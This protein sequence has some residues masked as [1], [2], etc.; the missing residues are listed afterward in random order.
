[1]AANL[2]PTLHKSPTRIEGLDQI[3]QGGLPTGRTT[4][5]I[6]GPG[7]GKSLFGLEFLYRGALSG[8]P[9]IFITFEER[10]SALRE[11]AGTLGWQLLPL[12]EKGLFFLFEARIDP[13]AVIAGE[14]GIQSFFAILDH[15]LKAMGARRVVIDALDVLMRL[16]NDEHREQNELVA[17]HR[18][19]EE[20]DI[21]ALVSVKAPR[22]GDHQRNYEFLDYLADC[23]I[24]LDNRMLGQLST[25]R[26]RV[27][28]YRGSGF[29]SNEY[30]FVIGPPGIMLLPISEVGLSH[31][32]LGKR[33][34]T[35]MPAVDGLIEGGFRRASSVLLSGSTGTGK[36]TFCC[37]FAQAACA[38]GEKVLYISFEES[39]AALLSTMLSPGIDLAPAIGAG[40]LQLLTAMPEA[41]GAEQHLVRTVSA[42][43]QLQPI[44]VV[45]ESASACKRMGTEQ[46]AF[47]YL[48]RMINTCKESGITVL[49]TNQ[50]AGFLNH[51]EISGIGISSLIDT[52]IQLLLVEDSNALQRKLLVMKARGTAHS[53]RYHDFAITDHGIELIP[54]GSLT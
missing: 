35:G 51:D 49:V 41:M 23:V 4:L 39:Q 43:R 30:P 32:A 50:T 6:G 17:M 14:F 37:A 25:R 1:M 33:F 34:P 46:A 53:H 19:L 42:V 54:E 18:W 8:A 7:A 10:A 47:E 45:L 24:H 36:T 22:D 28:K 2:L 20:R 5:V 40:S 12:E 31:Q 21:T 16:I 9:G 3:L 13:K 48:M 11:N 15:K 27:L 38:R 29:G 44:C 52:V 26:L